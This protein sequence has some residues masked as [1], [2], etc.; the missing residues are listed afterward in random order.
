MSTTHYKLIPEDMICHGHKYEL[1]KTYHHDKELVLCQSGFHCSENPLH[2]LDFYS[3]DSRLFE[4][5][6]GSKCIKGRNKVVT[7]EITLLR[8]I[9]GEE[10]NTLL[11]GNFF[12]IQKYQVWYKN[13]KRHR[14]GDLPAI[15]YLGGRKEWYQNG[16][17]HREGDLPAIENY[18]GTKEWW[19]NGKQHREGD[20]PVVVY[21]DS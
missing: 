11:T 13:G 8:E 5:K 3:P 2:C 18:D 6:I 17:L 16:Q 9:T 12:S 1:G 19:K 14:E 7:D 10:K 15:E 21:S 4:V 20:L